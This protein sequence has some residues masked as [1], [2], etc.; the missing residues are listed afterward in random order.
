MKKLLAT[1]TLGFLLLSTGV[2]LIASA[3]TAEVPECD[4]AFAATV[5]SLAEGAANSVKATRK[6]LYD[7]EVNPLG[8]VYEY[9]LDGADGY[10][11]FLQQ[12]DRFI[13]QEVIPESASP[14][15]EAEGK[16]IYVCSFTYLEYSDGDYTDLESGIILL[17]ET[18]EEMSE[19]AVYGSAG[20]M[21][22]AG[23]QVIIPFDT[24]DKHDYKMSLQPPMYF[25]SPYLSSCAC[26]A[27]ANIIGFYDRYYV[28]LIPDFEPG[29]FFLGVLYMYY[30]QSSAIYSV[31]DDLYVDMG[32]TTEHGTT[33][34][35][36]IDGMKKYCNRAGYSFA[37]TS[38][39]AG[40][41]VNYSDVIKYTETLNQPL[42][43]F[44]SGYNIAGI[45]E[46]DVD[47]GYGYYYSTGNHVMVGF[48][49]RYVTYT[50]NGTSNT[51]YF[52]YASSGYDS[53]PVG[54]FN[55]NF[56]T[57]INDILAINIY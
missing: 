18:I 30:G 8:Y 37:Y 47:D 52:I 7:I 49:Y 2:P 12:D 23:A 15:L 21:P 53:A 25:A 32:T 43:L 27:G 4:K 22:L 29:Y 38:L 46:G 33:E 13:P 55:I 45:S 42:A 26:I 31:I 10:A 36:F 6:P 14:Y 3:S 34:Q 35:Q 11:I 1:V 9:T 56:N 17:P 51:Y 44:L 50:Y 48:G 41:K 16:C 5:A 39:M 19:T 20:I 40:N 24:K 57:T 54:Y 28:N